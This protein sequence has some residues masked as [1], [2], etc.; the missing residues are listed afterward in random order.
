MRFKDGTELAADIVVMAV[1]IRPNFELAKKAGLYCER[2]I[3]VSDTMPAGTV[4]KSARW[5]G[6]T[7]PGSACTISSNL[8]TCTY[9]GILAAG[10]SASIEVKADVLASAVSP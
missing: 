5:L 1:G 3:V 4:L 2:G 9:S 6:T 10:G 8:L 7:P